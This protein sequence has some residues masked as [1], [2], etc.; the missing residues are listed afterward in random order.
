MWIIKYPKDRL[1]YIQSNSL[2]SYNSTKTFDFS[3]LYTSIPHSK[4]KDKLKEL[5]LLCFVKKNGQSRYKYLVL[6]RNKSYFVKNH[7]DSIKTIL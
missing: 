3:T 2:S 4:L 1:E 7:S 6:K 5:V